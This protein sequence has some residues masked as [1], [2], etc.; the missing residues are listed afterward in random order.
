MF[1]IAY[2]LFVVLVLSVFGAAAGA[3]AAATTGV[4]PIVGTLALA[5]AI[6]LFATF[7][8]TSVE[9]L[10]KYVSFLLYGTYALF[11]SCRWPAT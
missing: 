9:R 10:F 3:I 11:V 5:G 1:E 6:A 4:P 8:N 2:I 7:G